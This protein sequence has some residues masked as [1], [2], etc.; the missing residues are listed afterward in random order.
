MIE[1]ADFE[2]FLYLSRNQCVIFVENKKTFRS[3]YKEEIKI[4]DEIYQDD[5]SYLS[6][7]LDENIYRIEK[8]VGNFIKD[9]ML[10]IENDKILNLNIG[11]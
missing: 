8:L 1:E 6:I 2:T 4:G 10:I 3:L 5:F 7:F 11:I 9:I